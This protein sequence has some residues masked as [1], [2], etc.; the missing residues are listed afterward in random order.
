MK[1]TM[2]LVLSVRLASPTAIF[3]EVSYSYYSSYALYAPPFS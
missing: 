3:G 1:L 2:D